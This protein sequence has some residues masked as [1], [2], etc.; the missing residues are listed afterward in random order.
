MEF[1]FNTY[2]YVPNELKLR[3]KIVT[4]RCKLKISRGSKRMYEFQAS[5]SNICILP[6]SLHAQLHLNYTI[7]PPV[8]YR[9]YVGSESAITCNLD[10]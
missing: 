6:H 2:Y 8:T 9:K 3:C 7:G 10:L 5:Y 4:Q 1:Y